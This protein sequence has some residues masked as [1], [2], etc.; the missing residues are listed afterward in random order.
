VRISRTRMTVLVAL[1]LVAA[2]AGVYF[3]RRATGGI[4]VGGPAGLSSW[5]VTLTARGQLPSGKDAV[6]TSAPPDFRRQHVY[7]ESWK[8]GEVVH[9]EGRGD[10]AKRGDR[11][12]EATWKPRP[13]TA[14]GGEY[15]LTY[16]FRCVLGTR[17]PT[18]AMHAATKRLDAA[19]ET[20]GT[21]RP[22]SRIQSDH[23]EVE[24]LARELAGDSTAAADQVR[25]FHEHAFDLPY[26]GATGTGSAL[27]C[28]RAGGDA[29]GKSRLVVAL[30][31][32]RGIPARVVA[33][34][35][36]NPNAPPAAHHWAEAWVH[37]PDGPEGHWLPSCPTYGHLGDRR[38]PPNYLVVRLDDEPL[39]RGPG[40]PAVTFFARPLA[41]G[42]PAGE[43]RMQ[44]FWRATALASLPPA[45][46]QLAR[47]LVLLPL[48]AVV[49]SVFRVLIGI[50][51]YGVFAPALLGLIFR[52]LKGLPWGLGIFAATVL[53]GW[54][55]RKVLDRFH[56]LLIPRAAVMLTVVIGFLLVVV[57]VS[58]R[59]GVH[60]TG[61]LALFP[62]I[63]LTHMVE[64]FWTVEA[65]DGP[66]SSFK[67]LLG[68]MLVSTV[69]ALALSPD[70]VG[71]W[72]FRYPE[73]LGVVVAV[74]LLL[75]RYTGYRLTELYR[76][77]DVIEF[78]T[79]EEPKEEAKATAPEARPE[80]AEPALATSAEQGRH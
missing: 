37:S 67:T 68:T 71:R 5:E 39:V 16:T 29:A 77:Q 43:T 49:V 46:Q 8:S 18:P 36:L 20:D 47:F 10:A 27:D 53:V 1:G 40:N 33:G 51:T 34:L 72:V 63:I 7:N 22:T 74:L 76:F 55:F 66:W 45:E 32:S 14:P 62:L 50:R 21:L 31:R 65:E 79:K 56:L 23:R 35:V 80:V 15:R 54:L 12:R 78:E 28:L 9:R 17:H 4:D 6:V 2:S 75:G 11:E 73:T 41:D 38:W 26:A 61:Y 58:A 60:V 3:T 19:P 25:A 48:A 44:A 59:A 24:A 52:D 57:L 69:V 42:P 30:C 64:R 13:M 70:A